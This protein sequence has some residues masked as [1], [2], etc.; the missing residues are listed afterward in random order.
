[1][2][3]TALLEEVKN[4]IDITWEDEKLEE[5]L[6]GIIGRG[7][8]FLMERTG[9]LEEDFA[10]DSRAKALL[11]DYV[12][13]DRAAALNEFYENYAAELNSLM[14]ANEVRDAAENQ[15]ESGAV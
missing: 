5:K 3:I 1:M 9:A 7:I 8:T 6:T 4:D 11:F 15:E 13:Y 10:E 12:R 14:I 2:D